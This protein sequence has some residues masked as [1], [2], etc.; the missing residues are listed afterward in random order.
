MLKNI[1]KGSS[2]QIYGNYMETLRYKDILRVQYITEFSILE[3]QAKTCVG[4]GKN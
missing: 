2:I 3:S 4:I 1:P